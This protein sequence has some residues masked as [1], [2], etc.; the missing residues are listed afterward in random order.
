ML[1]SDLWRLVRVKKSAEEY[2]CVLET[3]CQDNP[4]QGR[5]LHIIPTEKNLKVFFSPQKKKM[6]EHFLRYSFSMEEWNGLSHEAIECF[7]HN[8]KN[9]S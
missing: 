1:R 6:A 2:M 8:D 3:S 7:I 4:L 5:S 9:R